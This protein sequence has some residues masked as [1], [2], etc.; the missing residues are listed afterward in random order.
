MPRFVLI[1]SLTEAIFAPSEK[2][3]LS[4]FIILL[5]CESIILADSFRKFGGIVSGPINF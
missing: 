1:Y 4:L 3:L 2:A 5:K